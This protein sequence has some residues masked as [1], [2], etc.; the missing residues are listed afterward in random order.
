[1]SEQSPINE[2]ERADL[3]AYLDGELK[4]EAARKV[5]SRIARDP[6]IRKEADS[7]RR[8]WEMLDYLPRAEASDQFTHRTLEKAAPVHA[9]TFERARGGHF[10]AIVAAAG[11]AA[12]VVVA[13]AVGYG[14]T[15]AKVLHDPGDQELV[16]DLRVI[17]NKRL[18]DAADDLDFVRELDAPELF[19]D[20][21]VGT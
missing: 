2:R 18:Y 10:L 4:G 17:E 21:T 12:A 13:L 11:W 6:S 14:A 8:A 7:L 19:G 3:V 20:D 1:M 5:E 15:R 9:P 16:R